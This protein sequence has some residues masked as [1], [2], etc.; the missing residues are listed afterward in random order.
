MDPKDSF[1]RQ[2]VYFIFF[3][4]IFA[5]GFVY[6][7]IFRQTEFKPDVQVQKQVQQK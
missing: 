7:E 4:C 1:P 3:F 5:Y 2:A 6:F